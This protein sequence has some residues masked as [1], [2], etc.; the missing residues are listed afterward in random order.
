MTSLQKTGLQEDCKWE[1]G[2]SVSSASAPLSVSMQGAGTRCGR[3][4]RSGG[5]RH[6]NC[7][8]KDRFT[9]RL[10][11]ARRGMVCPSAL[12]SGSYSNAYLAG[13]L[14]DALRRVA[15]RPAAP[16]P[17]L[18]STADAPSWKTS[19]GS[20][21]PPHSHIPHGLFSVSRPHSS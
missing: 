21:P 14:D 5:R 19:C 6:N 8:S 3:Q 13:G 9:G 1:S 16:P 4:C 20:P 15:V 7:A 2:H 10:R 11:G 17:H 12:R 18:R